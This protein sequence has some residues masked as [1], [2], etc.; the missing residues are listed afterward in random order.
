MNHE[1][2][3]SGCLRLAADKRRGEVV[4]TRDGEGMTHVQWLDRATRDVGFD[5]IVFPGD[6]TFRRIKTPADDKNRVYELM[7][8]AGQ[9]QRYFFWLQEPDANTDGEK[10]S[11]FLAAIEDPSAAAA[12]ATVGTTGAGAGASVL[13]GASGLGSSAGSVSATTATTRT[14]APASRTA[15]AGAPPIIDAATLDYILAG[16][17]VP[18]Q[19]SPATAPGVGGGGEGSG[20]GVGITPA[21]ALASAPPSSSAFGA[22]SG[23]GGAGDMSGAS[24]GVP[25]MGSLSGVSGTGAA[26]TD[27]DGCVILSFFPQ[28]ISLIFL[29]IFIFSLPHLPNPPPLPPLL[30]PF[31]P[32][33]LFAEWMKNYVW[34]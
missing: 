17:G 32:Y 1:P 30:P 18:V 5:R 19:A 12:A 7:Y 21:V 22:A 23:N 14:T 29:P 28:Q 9:R 10:I 15:V 4:L 3:R 33:I 2:G 20:G 34:H 26:L 27:D 11:K 6:A 13:G 31:S 24:S 8:V 16:L 25:V